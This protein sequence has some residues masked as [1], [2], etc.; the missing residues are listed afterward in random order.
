MRSLERA[1]DVLAAL[2]NAGDSLR[3]TD[4]SQLTSL[5]ASTVIRIL[6]VLLKRGYVEQDRAGRYRLGPLFLTGSYAFLSTDTRSRL[7]QPILQELSEITGFTASFYVR[8]EF[9]R[10]LTARVDG[11]HPLRYQIPIGRRLPLHLGGGK[12]LAAEL[13]GDELEQF[14]DAHPDLDHA[15]GKQVTRDDFLAD[16]AQIRRAG[17][18]HAWGEREAQIESLSVAVRTTNEYERPAMLVIAGPTDADDTNRLKHW[19]TEMVMAARAI[20]QLRS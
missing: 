5:H 6:G 9:S 11:E 20:E 7:A 10:V 4:I 14:L 12:V 16:L 17:Y 2:E 13:E 19:V 18:Y 8:H 3:L 1:F 15:S